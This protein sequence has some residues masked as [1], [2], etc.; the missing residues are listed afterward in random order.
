VI[1]AWPVLPSP[2]G[3]TRVTDEFGGEVGI[4]TIP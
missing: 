3:T 1:V 2:P 4:V